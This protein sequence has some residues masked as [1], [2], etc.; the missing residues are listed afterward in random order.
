MDSLKVKAYAKINLSFEVL[1]V[2][3]DGFHEIRT[4]LQ[5]IDLYDELEFTPSSNVTF[6]CN[7]PHLNGVDNLAYRALC[8]LKN[9]YS[10]DEG[11]GIHLRKYIPIGAGLGG[12]STDAAAVLIA[13]NEIWGLS[14]SGDELALMASRLGSD[15]PFFL[16]GGTA[17]AS[18]RGEKIETLQP[19]PKTWVLVVNA[20]SEIGNKTSTMYQYLQHKHFTDGEN[21]DLMVK[22][23]AS[24]YHIPEALIRNTFEEIEHEVFPGNREIRQ[25]FKSMGVDRVHLTGSGPSLFALISEKKE[26][27]QIIS[28]LSLKGIEAV[29]VSTI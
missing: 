29:L 11:I 5:T 27:E 22:L 7:V 26:G 24:G 2:R 1:G 19:I 12:G 18:G 15:V 28:Q 4:I 21:V 8:L 10:V 23:I 13:L 3:Q 16:T 9:A 25:L 17:F 14:L 6:Y 20:R